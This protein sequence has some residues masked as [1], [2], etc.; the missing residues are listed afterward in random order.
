MLTWQV[1]MNFDTNFYNKFNYLIVAKFKNVRPTNKG[2][3]TEFRLTEDPM[4]SLNT[5]KPLTTYHH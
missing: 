1:V 4:D 5:A 2:T 3:P